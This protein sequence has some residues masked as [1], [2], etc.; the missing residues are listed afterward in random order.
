MGPFFRRNLEQPSGVLRL[1][2]FEELLTAQPHDFHLEPDSIHKVRSKRLLWVRLAALADTLRR[3]PC[4]Q[5]RIGGS[6]GSDG[7]VLA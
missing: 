3:T 6:V 7:L 5:Q 4:D 1:V 2:K